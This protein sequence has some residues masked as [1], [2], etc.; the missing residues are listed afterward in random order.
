M[1]LLCMI[2]A[3]LCLA[4]CSEKQAEEFA[5]RKVLEL[6]LIKLCGDADKECGEA[7]KTQIKGCMEKSDWR[8]YLQSQDDKAE[9]K[10]F[11]NAFYAC[12]VDKNGKPYFHVKNDE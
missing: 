6:E 4:A 2:I 12:I 9:F 7:V 8:K 5:F 11:T 10:R 3:M 1:K